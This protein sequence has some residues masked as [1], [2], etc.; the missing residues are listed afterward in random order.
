MGEFPLPF[1]C[2]GGRTIPPE[3]RQIV[4]VAVILAAAGALVAAIWLPA[5]SAD[6][7]EPETEVDQDAL[8]LI[9]A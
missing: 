6:A 1:P 2:G 7:V 5:R 4:L 8:E 9:A 3:M